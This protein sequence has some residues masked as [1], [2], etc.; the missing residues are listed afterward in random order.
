MSHHV[1]GMEFLLLLKTRH[2]TST[3]FAILPI[4]SLR[5]YRKRCILKN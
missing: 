4:L 5:K 3:I 2:R 1:R